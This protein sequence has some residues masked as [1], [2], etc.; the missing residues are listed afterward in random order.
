MNSGRKNCHEIAPSNSI[1]PLSIS[2]GVLLFVLMS[3]AV[4]WVTTKGRFS[5]RT[6]SIPKAYTNGEYAR[7]LLD[8]HG[9]QLEEQ[10]EIREEFGGAI[11]N[12]N[13]GTSS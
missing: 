2:L 13:E 9:K 12:L 10:R 7:W 5:R 8:Q 3:I 4:F 1:V 6:N 11:T